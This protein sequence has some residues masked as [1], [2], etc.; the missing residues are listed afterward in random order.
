MG[1]DPHSISASSE[2]ASRQNHPDHR[3]L[4]G[5]PAVA[6]L[7]AIKRCYSGTDQGMWKAELL[8]G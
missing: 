8:T 3:L 6:V 7:Q 1:N 2:R 5:Q 4:A